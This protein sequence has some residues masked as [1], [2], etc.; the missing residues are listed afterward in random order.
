MYINLIFSI[1][2]IFLGLILGYVIQQLEYKKIIRLPI[3]LENLR[4]LLQ[5]IAL[6]F[7]LPISTIGT[8]WIIRMDNIKIAALPFLGVFALFSGGV[9]GLVAA[10]MPADRPINSA[11]AM[12]VERPG[13]APQMMP[14]QTPDRVMNRI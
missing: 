2:I 1:S 14:R 7:F 13:M 5:K 6:L 11:M 10:K 3:S 12:V 9:L 8:L 4:K